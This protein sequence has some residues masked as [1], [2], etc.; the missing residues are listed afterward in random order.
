MN[1]QKSTRIAYLENKNENLAVGDESQKSSTLTPVS[2]HTPDPGFS[3]TP[4]TASA[5]KYMP[6]FQNINPAITDMDLLFFEQKDIDNV[7]RCYK[8]KTGHKRWK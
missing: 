7:L 4:E 6:H 1:R 8:I 2:V 3:P 5:E